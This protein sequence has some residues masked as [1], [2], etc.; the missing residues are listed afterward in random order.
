MSGP[1]TRQIFED[2]P[3]RILSEG[4][5][6]NAEL[7]CCCINGEKWAVKDFSACPLMV[8]KTWGRWMTRREY[9]ILVRL[10]GIEGVPAEPFLLDA[11][12]VGYR[13]IQGK[14]LRK[15]EPGEIPTS[16]FY[17]L[18]ELVQRIHRFNIVHLDIRNRRNILISQNSRPYLLDFQ[19]GLDL[20]RIPCF[21]RGLLKDIDLSGVYK[22]WIRLRPDLMDEKRL[23]HLNV[24]GRK[25][26]LWI[27]KGRS[28]RSRGRRRY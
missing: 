6:A 13:F 15:A 4:R 18:E 23:A 19:S 12:A 11:Y 25:R 2:M 16:F 7:F 26:S 3:R 5:R 20:T 28:G 17:E 8:K 10:K 14:S 9:R 27:F 22:S 21:L 1:I 24:F